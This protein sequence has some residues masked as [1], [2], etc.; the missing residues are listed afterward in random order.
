MVSPRLAYFAPG[1]VVD[2]SVMWCAIVPGREPVWS[3][4]L[5]TA[6]SLC[7]RDP[8]GVKAASTTGQLSIFQ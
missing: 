2:G 3:R 8:K 5:C 4:Q 7:K 1:H 6:L